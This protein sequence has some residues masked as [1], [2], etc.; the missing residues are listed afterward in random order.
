MNF[1]WVFQLYGPNT[2]KG[3][4][5]FMIECQVAYIVRQL[6]RMDAEHLAWIDV[7]SEV[8]TDYNVAIQRDANA[9][10]VWA[11]PCNNYFRHA[12]SG[13]VVTQ[14]P[15]DMSQ[16]RKDTAKVDVDAFAVHAL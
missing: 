1:I 4:I 11:E 2:N 16:Y 15:R 13:R 5:L 14:Y 8:M 7:R 9:I 12:Q 3:S 6:A 10:A